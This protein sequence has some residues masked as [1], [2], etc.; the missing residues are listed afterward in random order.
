MRVF[1][2]EFNWLFSEPTGNWDPNILGE[3][4]NLMQFL[5]SFLGDLKGLNDTC[6]NKRTE[7][8]TSIGDIDNYGEIACVLQRK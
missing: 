7:N 5:M 2:M 1:T 3:N 4:V 8:F 6:R